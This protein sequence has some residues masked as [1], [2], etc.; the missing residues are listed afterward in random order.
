MVIA[1]FLGAELA[2]VLGA[3]VA[4]PT[5]ALLDVI[6]EEYLILRKATQDYATEEAV[7]RCAFYPLVGNVQH[8]E[9]ECD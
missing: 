3:L 6:A 8:H 9:S 4:V 7:R 2:G 1:L 5:A